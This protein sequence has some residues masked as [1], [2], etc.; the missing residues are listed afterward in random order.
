M[1]RKNLVLGALFM[2]AIVAILMNACKKDENVIPVNQKKPSENLYSKDIKVSDDNGNYIL[3]RLSSSEKEIIDSYCDTN[4]I[5]KGLQKSDITNLENN[6]SESGSEM[7]DM[8][9]FEPNG[10]EA[11]QVKQ[12]I[13]ELR[14]G[15]EF[16]GYSLEENWIAPSNFTERGLSWTW[17]DITYY[18]YA[19]IT[20]NRCC[21]AIAW[22]VYA[23]KDQNAQRTQ[24]VNIQE[25]KGRKSASWGENG[26]YAIQVEVYCRKEKHYTI[27]Y[28][29]L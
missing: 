18:E 16:T 19:R 2:L 29:N 3:F 8:E 9:V 23:F 4:F 20:N 11:A 5:F 10:E 7:N 12:T 17:E 15:A 6:D 22:N 14:L 13:V 27:T 26:I 25:I 21:W 1:K 28:S 24:M